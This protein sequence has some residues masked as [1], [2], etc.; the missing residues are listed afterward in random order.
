[1]QTEKTLVSVIV[2]VYNAQKHLKKCLDS[3]LSQSLPELEVICVDDG[4][5]D[6]SL[7]ILE[8]YGKEDARVIILRQE[9]SFAGTARNNGLRHAKGEFVAFLD[10]D[11]CYIDTEVLNDLFNQAKTHNLDVLKT[12]FECFDAGTNKIFS[13]SYSC[14]SC[15]SSRLS[16]RILTFAEHPQQLLHVADVPWNGLYRR[17]FLEENQI[18]FNSLRCINDHS[19]FV[20]CLIKAKRI[21]VT[22]RK[23]VYYQIEQSGS[24]IGGKA[25]H[26]NCHIESYGIVRNLVQDLPLQLRQLVLQ[27]ELY[28]LLDWYTRLRDKALDPKKIET[29]LLNFLQQYQEDDAGSLYLNS[30][31]FADLY[32]RK[33]YGIPASGPQPRMLVRVWRSWRV[34]GWRHVWMQLTEKAK[35]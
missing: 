2:P 23:T 31:R 29:E 4:S 10:A 15:I 33:R 24:L 27:Q 18:F 6:D 19:F 35:Q 30:F 28:S 16:K 20:H 11:D 32:S 7:S 25:N 8:Q 22:L 5:T 12:S 3:V 17:S 13:T 26:Y 9:N 21:M 1:M 14:N 34:Y